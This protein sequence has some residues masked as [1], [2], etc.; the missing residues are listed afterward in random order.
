MNFNLTKITIVFLL[1]LSFV[2]CLKP[3]KYPNEPIIEFVSFDQLDSSSAKLTF[4]FT[5]GDGDIGLEQEDVYPPYDSG[6][7]YHYN[8]YI[9]YFEMMDGEWVRA[10]WNPPYYNTLDNNF[11]DDTISWPFRLKNIT[12]N[13][14]NKALKGNVEVT[15]EPHFFNPNSVANNDTIMYKILLIDRSLS[16]SNLIS[17]PPIILDL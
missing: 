11:S 13:G 1:M 6:S 10:K 17:T 8:V 3:V 5:D 2:S 7:F 16:H 14:Q 15:I 4:S 12:P 9:N